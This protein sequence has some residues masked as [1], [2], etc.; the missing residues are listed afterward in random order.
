MCYRYWIN[1]G[2]TI[3]L[4]QGDGGVGKERILSDGKANP[5]YIPRGGKFNLSGHMGKG[6]M[7]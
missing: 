2:Y 7:A 1:G 3:K 5:M 4:S 6:L